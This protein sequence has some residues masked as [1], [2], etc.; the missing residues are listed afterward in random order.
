MK[1]INVCS[2]S[3]RLE[4]ISSLID[5]EYDRLSE[6]YIGYYD[7]EYKLIDNKE[8]TP[9]YILLATKESI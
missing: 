6:L 1:I 4:K 9:Y 8:K 2:K 7:F 3:A 5:Q